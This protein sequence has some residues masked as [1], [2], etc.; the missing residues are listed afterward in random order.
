MFAHRHPLEAWFD[1]HAS[2][3]RWH[4]GRTMIPCGLNLSLE[5]TFATGYA[6]SGGDPELVRLIAAWEGLPEE[7][8][9]PVLGGTGGNAVAMLAL[10]APDREL[11]VGEPAYYQWPGLVRRLASPWRSWSPFAEHPP[12]PRAGQRAWFAVSPDNPTGRKAPLE[13]IETWLGPL[14]VVVVDEIYRGVREDGM[15]PVAGR[16]PGWIGIGAMSKRLGL[17]GVRVGWLATTDSDM[18]GRLHDAQEHLAHSLPWATTRW[19]VRHWEQLMAWEA[20]SRRLAD[21]LVS[22]LA[23]QIDTWAER[24]FLVRV[25]DAGLS[26]LVESPALGDDVAIAQQFASRGI[27]VVP[28]SFVGYP[29]TLRI[30]LGFQY[31]SSA[32]EALD[33]LTDALFALPKPTIEAAEAC[34]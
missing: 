14:D 15:A 24:G 7:A 1:R 4:L 10:A 9:L 19:L 34:P 27:F 25:P 18:L 21:E 5:E 29:G 13:R 23:A 26:T 33:A 16:G 2:Q 30:S 11:M 20:T 28:G 3:A 31:A 6:P 17:P 32:I 22:I 8:I 12:Q